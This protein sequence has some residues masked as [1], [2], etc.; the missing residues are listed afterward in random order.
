[1]TAPAAAPEGIYAASHA[2]MPRWVYAR[3]RG[4]YEAID[5]Y[6]WLNIYVIGQ[7]GTGYK[8][9]A[10][11]AES[12]GI[13]IA[14][15]K[16]RIK[17][18]RDARV[19]E[20]RRFATKAGRLGQNVYVMV[21]FDPDVIAGQ[22]EG[23]DVSPRDPER[24]DPEGSDVSPQEFSQVTPEG[25]DVSPREVGPTPDPEGSPGEPTQRPAETVQRAHRMSPP[26]GSPREPSIN[27]TTTST[28]KINPPAEPL[29]GSPATASPPPPVEQPPLIPD[30]V[31]EGVLVDDERALAVIDPDTA[32]ALNA[33]RL[34]KEWIDYC[35]RGG[36]KLPTVAIKRYAASLKTAIDEGFPESVIRAA[37]T[38]MARDRVISRPALFAAYLTRAQTGPELPPERVGQA[39]A[40]RIRQSHAAGVTPDQAA[41][42]MRAFLADLTPKG[43]RS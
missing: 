15:V 1:M 12:M 2:V 13:S 6:L 43:Y 3:L 28:H 40:S 5:F 9:N 31:L 18:L 24:P 27:P 10:E 16:R 37:L 7:G 11:I 26:E 36:V 23:S 29:R 22:P 4:Q 41:D 19:M 30:E 33:G 35:G 39:E 17:A 32:P 25:S 8:R 21:P 34:T 38:L 20:V 14:A 42:E